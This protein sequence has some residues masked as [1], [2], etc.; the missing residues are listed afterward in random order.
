MNK[1]NLL[2]G[3]SDRRVGQLL[4]SLVREECREH[5]VVICQRTGS[6]DELIYFGC[7]E[8]F[9]LAIICPENLSAQRGLITSTLN[10]WSQAVRAV[11]AIKN[12][13]KTRIIVLGTLPERELDLLEAGADALLRKLDCDQFKSA[14]RKVLDLYAAPQATVTQPRSL[15]NSL[16]RAFQRLLEPSVAE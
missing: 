2:L 10:P 3:N 6:V 14:V 12:D 16:Q 5:G 1:I 7:T 13:R 8:Q 11:R 4:E 15:G 9:D